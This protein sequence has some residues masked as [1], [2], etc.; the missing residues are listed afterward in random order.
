M[1]RMIIVVSLT[2]AS[3]LALGGICEKSDE[4]FASA[5]YGSG[6]G[7]FFDRTESKLEAWVVELPQSFQEFQLNG[8][9]LE[10]T[11]GD[12]LVFSAHLHE[13]RTENIVWTSVAISAQER[14]QYTFNAL[15]EK[16][17][18]WEDTCIQVL[19]LPLKN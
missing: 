8:V 10:R 7:V 4:Q 14:N 17:P 16:Q 6:Y 9:R 5:L 11:I 1:R 12:E 13:Q 19:E 18:G 15:Y 3:S 2:G